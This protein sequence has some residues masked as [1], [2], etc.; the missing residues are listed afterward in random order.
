MEG[1]MWEEQFVR[2]TLGLGTTYLWV[3]GRGMATH[4]LQLCGKYLCMVRPAA[5]QW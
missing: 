3:V 2:P 5:D 1:K 4:R